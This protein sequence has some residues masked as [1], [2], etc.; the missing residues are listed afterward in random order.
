MILVFSDYRLQQ[1]TKEGAGGKG[2]AAVLI[3]LSTNAEMI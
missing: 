3:L 2:G 1:M